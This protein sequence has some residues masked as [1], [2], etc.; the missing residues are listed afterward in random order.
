[1]SRVPPSDG[2]IVKCRAGLVPLGA[3]LPDDEVRYLYAVI[4]Q[5]LGGGERGD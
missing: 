3:G 1:M 5:A 4:G 2:V